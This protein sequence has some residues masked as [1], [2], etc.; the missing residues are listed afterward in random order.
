MSNSPSC[1]ERRYITDGYR[2]A[3]DDVAN[4]VGVLALAVDCFGAWG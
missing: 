1:G 3:V 2:S 4:E